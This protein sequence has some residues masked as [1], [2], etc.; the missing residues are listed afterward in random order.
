MKSLKSY[1]NCNK[2]ANIICDYFNVS[3]PLSSQKQVHPKIDLRED[4]S[5]EGKWKFKHGLAFHENNY[6][7]LSATFQPSFLC[8]QTY[9]AF[10]KNF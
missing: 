3:K 7:K 6:F 9:G 2:S 10:K 5:F 4:Q 1:P 8:H